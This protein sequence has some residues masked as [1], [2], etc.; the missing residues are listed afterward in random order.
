[1]HRENCDTAGKRPGQP[2]FSTRADCRVAEMS[3]VDSPFTGATLAA[4][5]DSWF[6]GT[7]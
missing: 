1:M 6:Q 5:P 2:Q 7:F 4:W 3:R